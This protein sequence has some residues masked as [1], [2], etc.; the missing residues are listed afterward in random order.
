MASSTSTPI[1]PESPSF[2]DTFERWR[3]AITS[4]TL[5]APVRASPLRYDASTSASNSASTPSWSGGQIMQPT[6]TTPTSHTT[7]TAAPVS[8]QER[9]RLVKEC[10]RCEKWTDELARESP[11]IRFLLMHVALLPPSPSESTSSPTSSPSTSYPIPITCRPCPPTLAGGFSPTLGIL[12]CQN[13]FMSK[14]HLQDAL[15]HELIHAYDDRRFD[16]GKADDWGKDLRK[17]ACTEIRA[18]NLSGDCRFSREFTRRNWTLTK[19]HQAC[20]R[21]RATLSVAANPY[22]KDEQE[23]QKIVNEVWH[24]CWPD[25]RPFDEIY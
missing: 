11:I 23:A 13:R 21:R 17:H 19:Q 2:L 5:P 20:V 9:K 15:A 14:A 25:T 22:C 7:A 8:E 6:T 4:L 16:L 10:K 3:I 24:N 12:L 18:E 1:D